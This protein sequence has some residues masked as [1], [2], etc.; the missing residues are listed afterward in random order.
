MFSGFAICTFNTMVT[1]NVKRNYTV[2]LEQ[3]A[4]NTLW[5]IFHKIP[6]NSDVILNSVGCR[7]QQTDLIYR[8]LEGQGKESKT[9]HP[10]RVR[11]IEE[12]HFAF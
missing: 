4:E 12:C 11:R 10:L 2:G 3:N 7:H 6:L 1:L 9:E 8:S 5:E